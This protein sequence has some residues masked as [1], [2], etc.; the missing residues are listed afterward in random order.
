MAGIQTG[1]E[2]QDNFT[3]VIMGIIN[4]VNLAVSVMDSLDQSM[5]SGINTTAIQGARDE[6]ND[7]AAAASQLSREFMGLAGAPAIRPAQPAEWKSDTLTPVVDVSGVERYQQEVQ[8]TG[9]MLDSLTSTQSRISQAAASMDILPETAVQDIESLG[10][11]LDALK[12]KIQEIENNPVTMGT[13]AASAE[14]EQ[15]YAQLGRVHQEQERLN[16]AAGS[17]DISDINS[18]YLRLSQTI[19]STER[20]L[21]DSAAHLS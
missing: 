12:G 1:I 20:Y 14:L 11:R 6:I 7:A 15:L 4:S 18:A 10:T 3:S 17:M 8:R 5:S 13:D 2:L 19:S 9:Q 21:R 16:D